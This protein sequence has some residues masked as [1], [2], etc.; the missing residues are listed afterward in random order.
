MDKNVTFLYQNNTRRSG[1]KHLAGSTVVLPE[2]EAWTKVRQG[3]GIIIER[4]MPRRDKLFRQ[5]GLK[6]R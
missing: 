1:R 3:L 6:E 2:N 4:R 5:E